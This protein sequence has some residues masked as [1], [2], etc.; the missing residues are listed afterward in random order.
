MIYIDGVRSYK[1]LASGENRGVWNTQMR[2]L[3]SF[4][5]RICVKSHHAHNS[6]FLSVLFFYWRYYSKYYLEYVISLQIKSSLVPLSNHPI[7]LALTL[8]EKIPQTTH[9]AKCFYWIQFVDYK[10][11]VI[12]LDGVRSY[13]NLAS[14]K[15]RGVWK[16][17][18]QYAYLY[19]GWKSSH[20]QLS[21]SFCFIFFI[22]VITASII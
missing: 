1:N 6:A 3:M 19:L 18:M 5:M 11:K 15:N 10:I 9:K 8:K 13:K 21:F 16:T 12:Y 14:G 7:N 20:S 17:Q 2:H 4:N 22:D